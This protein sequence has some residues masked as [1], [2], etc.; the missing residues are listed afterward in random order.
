MT[1]WAPWEPANNGGGSR[2]W[3]VMRYR[4]A[5]LA[6]PQSR[7]VRRPVAQYHKDERGHIIRYT[8]DGAFTTAEELNR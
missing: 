2:P 8:R 3:F 7:H 6:D 1:T 4:T 5:Y